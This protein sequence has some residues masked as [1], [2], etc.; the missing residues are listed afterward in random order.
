MDGSG[1][2]YFN[3]AEVRAAIRVADEAVRRGK[4]NPVKYPDAGKE[5]SLSQR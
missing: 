3:M 1:E 5:N 4:D 2:K